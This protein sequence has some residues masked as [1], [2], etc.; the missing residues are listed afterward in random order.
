MYSWHR[1]LVLSVFFTHSPER[2][3]RCHI[4]IRLFWDVG[5]FDIPPHMAIMMRRQRDTAV[6]IFAFR[7]CTTLDH[8]LSV[9]L[10]MRIYLILNTS[11]ANYLVTLYIHILGNS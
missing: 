7:P 6:F 1:P 4:V 3:P 10:F 9:F 2:L 5:R 8:A 11:L